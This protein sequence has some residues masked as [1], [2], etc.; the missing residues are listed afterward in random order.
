MLSFGLELLLEL[1][2]GVEIIESLRQESGHVDAVGAGQAHVLIELLVEESLLHQSLTVVEHTVYF[3]GGDVVA[4][5]GELTLLDAAHLPLGIEHVDIDTVYTKKT[6]G[7]SRSR[8]ATRGHENVY[9]AFAADEMAEHAGHET[10]ADILESQRGTMEEFER[11]DVF[12]YFHYGR[13]EL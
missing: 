11:I 12:L 2:V 5:R 7:N 6:I 3:D 1:F 10:G 13:W 9:C 8:I 4:Q